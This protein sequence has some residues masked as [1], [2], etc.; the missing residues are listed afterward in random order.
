MDTQNVWQIKKKNG[1]AFLII[2]SVVVA[3]CMVFAILFGILSNSPCNPKIIHASKATFNGEATT[4]MNINGIQLGVP[5]NTTPIAGYLMDQNHSFLMCSTKSQGCIVFTLVSDKKLAS[6]F[7]II[8]S[9]DP[10]RPYWI[11]LVEQFNTLSLLTF[12]PNFPVVNDINLPEPG[13]VGDILKN[14]D[15]EQ[16]VLTPDAKTLMTVRVSTI[17]VD[18]KQNSSFVLFLN[19]LIDPST[20]NFLWEQTNYVFYEGIQDWDEAHDDVFNPNGSIFLTGHGA[21]LVLPAFTFVANAVV[22]APH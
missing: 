13:I 21:N 10:L 1:V 9:K 4:T 7:Q 19:S 14:I 2:F 3:V 15:I 17:D 16:M 5:Q 12:R 8:P 11:A 20:V 18:A 22:T 6:L